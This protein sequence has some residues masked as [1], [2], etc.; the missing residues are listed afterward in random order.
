M[1]T[2]KLVRK[3]SPDARYTVETMIAEGDLVMLLCSYRGTRVSFEGALGEPLVA[4]GSGCHR[5]RDGREVGLHQTGSTEKSFASH[6]GLH[7][8]ERRCGTALPPGLAPFRFETTLD[9][10]CGLMVE[11]FYQIEGSEPALVLRAHPP[12]AVI[13]RARGRP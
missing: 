9:N 8:A 11:W 5:L 7:D 2:V 3:A 13:V 6:G 12:V 4:R 1:G 10:K